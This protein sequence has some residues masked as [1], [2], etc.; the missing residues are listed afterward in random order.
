MSKYYLTFLFLQINFGDLIYYFKG[1][2]SRKNFDK[3]QNGIQ[4][5][6]KLKS[7]YVKI[8]EAKQH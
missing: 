3:F 8:V 2:S 5:F 6:E 4:F 7:G 1:D